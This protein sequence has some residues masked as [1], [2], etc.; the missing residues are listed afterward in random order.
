MAATLL[1]VSR[2]LTCTIHLAYSV[3]RTLRVGEGTRNALLQRRC[4][5]AI[6]PSTLR[7]GPDVAPGI[8]VRISRLYIASDIRTNPPPPNRSSLRSPVTYNFPASASAFA[9]AFKRLVFS[10]SDDVHLLNET[11][12][13]TAQAASTK[14]SPTVSARNLS[15]KYNMDCVPKVPSLQFFFYTDRITV[16]QLLTHS[17]RHA[18]SGSIFTSP[19]RFLQ[20]PSCSVKRL[21]YHDV[22]HICTFTVLKL[23]HKKKQRLSSYAP[24]TVTN[25]LTSIAPL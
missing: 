8:R 20:S 3:A 10:T 9:L 5:S 4:R 24:L 1:Y 15:R 19:I 17:M 22:A 14:H 2:E 25:P 18:F 13:S 12:N 23:A 11:L 16:I 7:V 6:S 21:A